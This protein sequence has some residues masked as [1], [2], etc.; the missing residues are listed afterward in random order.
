MA[1]LRSVIPSGH[2]R[3]PRDGR[4]NCPPPGSIRLRAGG[5]RPTIG[6]IVRIRSAHAGDELVRRTHCRGIPGVALVLLVV[7][8]ANG[9]GAAWGADTATTLGAEERDELDRGLRKT[10]ARL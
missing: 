1:T 4:C 10:R 8:Q 9:P 2:D 5:H 6:R 3:I 7:A